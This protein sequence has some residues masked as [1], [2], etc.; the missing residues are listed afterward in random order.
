MRLNCV[1]CPDGSGPCVE[2][3]QRFDSIPV[4]NPAALVFLRNTGRRRVPLS[5]RRHEVTANGIRNLEHAQGV[6][7]DRHEHTRRTG[8]NEPI[9]PESPGSPEVSDAPSANPLDEVPVGDASSI[10]AVIA[11]ER[12]VGRT[13][14]PT[15]HFL[16]SEVAWLTVAGVSRRASA[17]GRSR[18]S[19]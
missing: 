2:Q 3:S 4:K 8:S 6:R 5:S 9:N 7:G 18:R 19:S 13:D 1:D 16:A 15:D 14:R 10:Q 12:W 11:E 17:S